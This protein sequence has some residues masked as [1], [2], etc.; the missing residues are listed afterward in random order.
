MGEIK[1][2]EDSSAGNIANLCIYALLCVAAGMLVLIVRHPAAKCAGLFLLSAGLFA[3]STVSPGKKVS[4]HFLVPGIIFLVYSLSVFTQMLFSGTGL[5]P[6]VWWN[7]LIAGAAGGLVSFSRGMH[8]FCSRNCRGYGN[9]WLLSF[10]ILIVCVSAV[11]AGA[12]I[13][14]TEKGSFWD[15]FKFPAVIGVFLFFF[16][17]FFSLLSAMFHTV[18]L[19]VSIKG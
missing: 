4:M 18:K 17:G 5:I 10:R 7:I 6:S 16:A 19:F 11:A 2:K 15:P 14:A 8:L 3:L 1:E 13:L 9:E 12:L